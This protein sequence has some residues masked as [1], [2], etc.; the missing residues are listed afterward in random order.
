MS[1]KSKKDTIAFVMGLRATAVAEIRTYEKETGKKINILYI[2]DNKYSIPEKISGYDEVLYVDFNSSVK[3]EAALLPYQDRLIA[4]T[5][6]NDNNIARFAKIIPNVPYLRTPT[7]ESITWATDKYEMR[8][9]FQI[10]DKTITP[11][12]T[13]IK[14][15]T[16]EERE[17]VIVKVGF[18]MIIKPTNL[19][20]SLFVDIC[21]HEEELRKALG[22]GFRKIR[23]AYKKDQRLEKPR[24]IVEQFVEGDLYSIDS[25]V[26]SRGNI[27]HC[28]LVRVKTG[29][30]IGH[31]DFFG[32]LQITPTVLKSETIEKARL[33]TEKAI[34][35]L[36][37]RSC[38]AHTELL[39]VDGEW[40]VVEVGPRIGGARDVLYKLSCDID[41]SLNDVKIRIPEKV[42]IPKK[43]KGYAAYMKWFAYK[44]GFIT[45]MKGV[46]KIEQLESFESITVNKKLGDKAVFASRGGRSIFILY[47]YNA[48]RSK[49]LADIRRIEEMVKVKVVRRIKVPEDESVPQKK[50]VPKKG[51][52]KNSKKKV[53]AKKADTKKVKKKVKKK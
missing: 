51:V 42:V 36:G 49:L 19:G 18:P 9:R 52:E 1:I 26:D 11:V 37:L 43:C 31:K 23:A 32:Y 15:N 33:V 10:Y 6:T 44:E 16:T 30:D 4:I 3:I 24:I 41:H 5:C 14:E 47:L 8:R 13:Q 50:L 7:T 22:R 17:R 34:H 28:P 21:Y 45:E 48:E 27:H 53:V 20:A 35:A 25:Y 12:F 39:K 46:K 40:K 29:K 2:Q 38:S